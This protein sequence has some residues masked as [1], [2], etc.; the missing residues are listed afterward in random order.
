[1]NISLSSTFRLFKGGVGCSI[2]CRCEGCKNAFGRKDGEH[3]SKS[4]SI[5]FY[6]F[7]F[8]FSNPIFLCIRFD[9]I[10]YGGWIRRRRRRKRRYWKGYARQ[11]PLQGSN[12]WWSWASHGFHTFRDRKVC[13]FQTLSRFFACS[14]ILK[15]L[16]RSISW[17]SSFLSFNLVG[18]HFSHSRRKGRLELRFLPSAHTPASRPTKTLVNQICFH[19]C[20]NSTPV[21]KL[22]KK[23]RCRI[24]SKEEDRIRLLAESSLCPQIGREFLH[25]RAW[26]RCPVW[27]AVGSWYFSRY[28]R[29]LR[30]HRISKSR[31]FDYGSEVEEAWGLCSLGAL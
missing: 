4:I 12:P 16:T 24:F 8:F 22:S 10:W 9:C 1:M 28:L 19:L 23:K 18:N 30:C 26:R 7:A 25:L 5:L 29:S 15:S 27:G 20:R 14:L 31:F 17:R 13:R 3:S 21:L 11:K 6:I 2:N